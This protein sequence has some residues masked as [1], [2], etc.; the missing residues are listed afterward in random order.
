MSKQP[1]VTTALNEQGRY[2]LTE[3]NKDRWHELDQDRT[4]AVIQF[5]LLALQVVQ[6]L[7]Q[8]L[9]TLPETQKAVQAPDRWLTNLAQ[10]QGL[11]IEQ[12]QGID[13]EEGYIQFRV[14]EKQASDGK[15]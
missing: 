12:F 4:E 10:K 5:G 7:Q 2:Y 14:S 6:G 9:V 1:K 3:A 11:P 8:L 13:G 15:D